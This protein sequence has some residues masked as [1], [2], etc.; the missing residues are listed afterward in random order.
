MTVSWVFLALS[1]W[2]A[3]FTWVSYHPPRKPALVMVVGFFA[4]WLTTEAA[5]IHLILQV[6]GTIV[7]AYYG[8]FEY[9][10]AW[11]ALAICIASWAGLVTSIRESLR[12]DQVFVEAMRETFGDEWDDNLDPVL[13]YAGRHVNWARVLL[14]LWFRRRRVKRK[15]NIA[16]IP[17]DTSKKHKLDVYYRRDVKPGAPVLLQIPGGGWMISNKDQQGHPMLYHLAARGWICVATNYRLSPKA[18]WPD[19]IVDVK[20]ALAWVKE[21]IAEFN[22]DPDYVVVTGGSAG[23]HITALMGLTPNDPAFQPGF[24]DVDTS[25]RAMI[26]IYGVFDWTGSA[27]TDYDDG[28]REILEKYIVKQTYKDAP[29]LYEAASPIMR[30]NPDAPPALIIHGDLDTLAPVEEARAFVKQL[31]A[32]S[33]HSVVYAEL[34]GAHHAFDVFNSIRTMKTI[35]SIDL[36]LAWLVNAVPIRGEMSPPADGP[37][38]TSEAEPV[39]NDPSSTAR[40]AH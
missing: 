7:F 3:A 36:Y 2:C 27:R 11:V 38:N 20:R 23:G 33:N 1:I 29:A 24:E 40:T 4:S 17:G 26:P 39:A 19:H 28:L 6:G 5:P 18:T 34:H 12:T 16:Y 10:P 15:K 8:A 25:V 9:W 31:R 21:H 32:V 37:T 14:P 35:A 22:G 30:V 13:E